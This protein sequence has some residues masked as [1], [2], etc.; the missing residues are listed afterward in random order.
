MK[1]YWK[2]TRASLRAF[3]RGHSKD[4]ELD[5]S[6]LPSQ[7]RFEWHAYDF[8]WYVAHGRAA[9]SPDRT[10]ALTATGA[11]GQKPRTRRTGA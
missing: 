8:G 5:L 7:H 10:S 11:P 4:R 2:L 3:V 9:E 6:K 1:A